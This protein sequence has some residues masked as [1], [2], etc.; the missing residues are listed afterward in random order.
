[1]IKPTGYPDYD[2][3]VDER[4]KR[5]K[6]ILRRGWT[7]RTPPRSPHSV[8]PSRLPNQ[9]LEDITPTHT[10]RRWSDR[11]T[12]FSNARNRI[13]RLGPHARLTRGEVFGSGDTAPTPGR[14]SEPPIPPATIAPVRR[15]ARSCTVIRGAVQPS[16]GKTKSGNSN[17][18]SSRHCR[19][20]STRLS[21]EIMQMIISRPAAEGNDVAPQFEWGSPKFPCASTRIGVGR[22]W[23]TKPYLPR[24]LLQLWGACNDEG[25]HR[26]GVHGRI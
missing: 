15:N 10:Q 12:P 24:H 17:R 11:V 4:N 21:T 26:L 13:R 3:R 23:P 7:T 8:T 6:L 25:Q 18:V 16:T 1:M 5:R 20:P 22:A 19:V 14:S 2:H 9:I